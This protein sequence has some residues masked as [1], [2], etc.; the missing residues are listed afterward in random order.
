MNLSI[1]ISTTLTSISCGECGGI[2]AITECYRKQKHDEGGYWSCP[3]CQSDWG[4][5]ESEI[6]RLKKKVEQE[7][8]RTE[9]AKQDLKN[10]ENKLRAAKGQV[11]KIKNRVSK[12]AC[13]CCNRTFQ[14]LHR[15]MENQ[16]PNW[17]KINERL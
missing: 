16:H 9:W 17:N 3:Y 14:N 5:D 13:P 2:Y 11:T 10:T 15:H 12:G 6:D 7:K 1:D 8:K 4:Y